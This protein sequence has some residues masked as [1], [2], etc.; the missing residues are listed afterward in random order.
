MISSPKKTEAAKKEISNAA[1]ILDNHLKDKQWIVGNRVTLAD[2]VYAVTLS[3]AFKT[4]FGPEFRE[5]FP[6]LTAWFLR[7]VNEPQFKVVMGEVVLTEKEAQV[8]P[9]EITHNH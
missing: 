3:G 9:T 4:V 1:T 7:A 6:H 2:I 5:K 8:K